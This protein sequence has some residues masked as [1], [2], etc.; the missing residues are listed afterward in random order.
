MPADENFGINARRNVPATLVRSNW[1]SAHN[2]KENRDIDSRVDY[3][4]HSVTI[5]GICRRLSCDKWSHRTCLPMANNRGS[6][7]Q[8]VFVVTCCCHQKPLFSLDFS[9]LNGFSMA[10][11]DSL[12]LFIADPSMGRT[13]KKMFFVGF[14]DLLFRHSAIRILA[15]NP[16][17]R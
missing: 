17:V 5:G 8:F 9:A 15:P 6:A 10:I 13:G 4:D 16:A 3:P 1:A 14:V 12:I 7:R 11:S 2:V